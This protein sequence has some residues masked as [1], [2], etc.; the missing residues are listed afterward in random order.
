MN[1][2][3]NNVIDLT[4]NITLSKINVIEISYNNVIHFKKFVLTLLITLF[5]F[6]KLAI[7]G[8]TGAHFFG[9]GQRPEL[10]IFQLRLR[11]VPVPEPE[12][13]VKPELG[14]KCTDS[15]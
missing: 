6:L 14:W 15:N 3:I 13:E 4:S 7:P 1:N 10:G 5:N 8:C 12:P 2:V 9:S 11:P